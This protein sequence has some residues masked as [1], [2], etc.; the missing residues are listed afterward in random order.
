MSRR[1]LDAAGITDPALRGEECAA[2]QL[3]TL[4]HTVTRYAIDRR[5]LDDFMSATALEFAAGSSPPARRA[6]S[7]GEAGPHEVLVAPGKLTSR[8]S[9]RRSVPPRT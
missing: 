6:R 2:P 4:A 7:A 5:H 3:R 1:A 9:P 8:R